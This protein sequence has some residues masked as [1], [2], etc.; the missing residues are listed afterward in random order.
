MFLWSLWVLANIFS[1]VSVKILTGNRWHIKIR[2]FEGSLMKS[3]FR[4]MQAW[5]RKSDK[6]GVYP[7]AMVRVNTARPEGTSEGWG[8][9]QVGLAVKNLPANA[10]DARD[11]GSIPGL[12]RSPGVGSGNHSNILAW[13]ILDRGLWWGYKESDMTEWLSIQGRPR[14]RG[15]QRGLPDCGGVE[16][17][18]SPAWGFPGE[19][20]PTP[21]FFLLLISWHCTTCEIWQEPTAKGYVDVFWTRHLLRAESRV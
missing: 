7:C 11:V 2:R 12:G 9:S 18:R 14:E 10:G 13:K 4:R 15:E 16:P 20:P 3:Q 8:A 5:L 21:T 17:S 6:D 1:I 19:K